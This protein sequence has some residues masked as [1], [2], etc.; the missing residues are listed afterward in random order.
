MYKYAELINDLEL[1]ISGDAY[2]EGDRLPSIRELSKRYDCSKSTVIRAL[3]ELQDK[4]L[5]YAAPKSGYYVMKRSGK[6]RIRETGGSI[7]RRLRLIRI[8]F[9]IWIFSIVSIKRSICTATTCSFTAR[10]RVC[11]P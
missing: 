7:L 4:H 5:I 8:F 3:E 10:L 9:R 6:S 11:R 1:Q 2:K